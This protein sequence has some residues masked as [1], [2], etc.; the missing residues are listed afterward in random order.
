MITLKDIKEK[1]KNLFKKSK[2]TLEV[3]KEKVEEK[4]DEVKEAVE[5]KIEED[6]AYQAYIA[7]QEE[8]NK[9]DL[10]EPIPAIMSP[11]FHFYR[12]VVFTLL[13]QTVAL[14]AYMFHVGAIVVG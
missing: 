3:I 4:V 2:P 6:A 14:L 8:Q 1:G 12:G 7:E 13:M 5:T 11:K 9:A 10:E